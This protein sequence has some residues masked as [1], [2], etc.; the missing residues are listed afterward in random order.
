MK[1]I[2]LPDGSPLS[3]KNVQPKIFGYQI[4]HKQTGRILPGTTRNEI[5]SKAGAIK[6]MNIIAG[7]YDLMEESLN[8]WDYT[9]KVIYDYEIPKKF[10]YII[11][12]KDWLFR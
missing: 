5:Y 6:K 7:Q 10:V 3:E 2:I 8:I 1:K 4:V 12:E 9:L 11:D